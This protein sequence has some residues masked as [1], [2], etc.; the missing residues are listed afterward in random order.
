MS[1]LLG[2]LGLG[3]RSGNVAVGVEAV[4]R[5]LQRDEFACVVM[6]SNASPRAVEKVERLARARRV[7]VVR[8][9]EA[10]AIGARLGRPPVM[11]AGVRDRALADGIQ[12]AVS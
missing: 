1:R 10:D 5:G 3:L 7:L 12:R 6:A 2:L 11:A 4:R 9:P 8:G